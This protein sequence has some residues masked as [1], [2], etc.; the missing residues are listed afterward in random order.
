MYSLIR[1]SSISL[2]AALPVCFKQVTGGILLVVLF[3]F[4]HGCAVKN[5]TPLTEKQ[6]VINAMTD[7][8]R[9]ND[10]INR[11]NGFL[12]TNGDSI[13]WYSKLALQQARSIAYQPAIARATLLQASCNRRNGDF[14]AAVPLYLSAIDMFDSLKL[15]H[16]QIDASL[17]LAH[18]YKE[19]S[20][21]K[22][23][24]GYMQRALALAVQSQSAATGDGYIGGM[25]NS[26][27][28]QG[29]I[30]R[31]MWK[32]NAANHLVD[33]A[34]SKYN[35]ALQLVQETGEAKDQLGK[36]YNNISQVYNERDK[37]FPLALAYLRKAVDFNTARNNLNSLSFNY[38]NI[39]DVYLGMGNTSEAHAYAIKMLEVCN[40]LKAPH[41]IINAYLALYRIHKNSHRYDSAL[42]YHEMTGVISDSLTNVQKA[43]QIADMQVKYESVKKELEISRLNETDKINRQRIAGFAIAAFILLLLLGVLLGLYR[44]LQG[45]KKQIG[46]QSD[47]LQWM[48]KELHHRV[49]NNL[50]IV[51]SLLNLQSYRLKDSESITALKE[52]QLRVQAMSLIHQRLYQADDVSLVNFKFY[53]NDLV[54]TL[55][56]AYGYTADEFDLDI[57]IDKEL[58]D[59]DTV[60]PMGLMVN[61]I[62]TNAFKYAFG[63]YKR[64]LLS[65]HLE[66]D[67]RQLQLKIADNGPGLA[68]LNNQFKSKGFGKSLIDALIKQLKGSYS[69]NGSGGTAYH[70][71]IPNTNQ[72]AA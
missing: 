52:S 13:C 55:M 40:R 22:G 33:S 45:Q 29:I 3:S 26:L 64:P 9:I 35:E 6:R 15:K 14:S 63:K 36:L 47:R 12:Q 28:I 65:I 8:G 42:Y 21:E 20:G 72:Q 44:R 60:L 31:D 51:S 1:K 70:F 43:G 17:A 38:G 7:T 30:L 58:M 25:V 53:I 54:E 32:V 19:M 69:V 4:F 49:K 59:V 66:D 61:E 41:R 48:M 71:L 11:A 5:D 10:L 23:T 62:I 46:E 56:K 2:L 68:V 37:N 50:Q 34:F 18:S 27:S 24:T 67:G 39:S 16:E 57:R